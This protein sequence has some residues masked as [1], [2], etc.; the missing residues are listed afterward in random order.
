MTR[1]K[2]TPCFPG[3]PRFSARLDPLKEDVE[4][5][6]NKEMLSTRLLDCLLQ[7]ACPPQELG[8]GR[9]LFHVSALSGREYIGSVNA[10]SEELTG[11]RPLPAQRRLL[12][13][14]IRT[15]RLRLAKAFQ[16][17]K[18]VMNRLCIPIVESSHFFVVVVEFN[19][20]NPDFFVS[21]SF[22]DS[23]RRST[24]GSRA[25]PA[26]A[27]AIVAEVNEFFNNFVLY[28]REHQVW[29]HSNAE[30]LKKVLYHDCPLQLNGIDCGLFCVGVVLHLLD[31][32]NVDSSTFSHQDCSRLR[33]RLSTHFLGTIHHPDDKHVINQTPCQIVPKVAE[34][35]QKRWD[36]A[37]S[38]TVMELEHGCGDFKVVEMSS[39]QEEDYEGDDRIGQTPLSV[40]SQVI[41]TVKPRQQ[42]CS[43]GMWQEFLYPCRHGCAVYR[44][45]EEKDINYVLEKVVH[46]FYRYDYVQKLFNQNVFPS[47]IDN[48]IYDGETKPPRVTGRQAGRPRTKRIRRRSEFMDPEKSPITCSECGERGHNKRTCKRHLA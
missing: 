46:V 15:L 42:W 40:G 47:C 20:S 35:L 38:L 18:E 33:L 12:T 23:M 6:G 14:N 32:I 10:W 27:A 44:I 48:A 16:M 41:H 13:E 7:R 31:G 21:I 39:L 30:L 2:C 25:V 1:S 24:R 29:V 26:A 28:K 36:A 9:E 34:H 8:S 5:L 45:W 11:G 17:E 4:Q 43:C 37:A 3:D 22:Y 19:P